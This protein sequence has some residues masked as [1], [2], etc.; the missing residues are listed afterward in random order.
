M[1]SWLEVE[2]H[3]LELLERDIGADTVFF[4]DQSGP[5]QSCRGVLFETYDQVQRGWAALATTRAPGLLLKAALTSNGVVI[6]SELF[7]STLREHEYYQ[8]IM[9][10]HGGYTTLFGVLATASPNEVALPQRAAKAAVR[11]EIV[12]GRC[13][14]T[15]PFT[16]AQCQQLARLLP[17]L[18]LAHRAFHPAPIVPVSKAAGAI[19]AGST[20]VVRLT[21]R[22]REVVGY[23][24]LGYTNRQIGMALGTKERTVRNQLSQIYEKLGVGSRAEVVGL[25]K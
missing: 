12:L 16:Q 17:T 21:E 22:E 24:H 15:K 4:M 10:P 11:G 18:S 7:G 5:T 9:A 25:L 14:G 3:V 13:R 20:A 6:D 2:R 19:A 23:L 1:P 8:A